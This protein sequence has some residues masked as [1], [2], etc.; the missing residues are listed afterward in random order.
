[1]KKIFNLPENFVDESLKGI[2]LAHPYELK[3]PDGDTRAIYR[4]DA[5]VKGKVAIITGGGYGH[6]PLF[7]GYV[8]EGLCDG[9]AVGNVFTSPSCETIMNVT[10]QVDSG[11]GVLYLFGNYMG[12]QM[13]FEMA[14]DFMGMEGIETDIIRAADDIASAP[15]KNWQERRGIAGIVFAYKVAGAMAER[16]GTLREVAAMTRRA[17][18]R[19]ASFGVS[20]TSCQLPESDAPI[21]EI[22]DDEMELGMG[23]HGEKGVKR[24]KMMT[25]KEI[26]DHALDWICDDICIAAGDRVGVLVN[27]LGSTSREELYI[28][29]GEVAGR[30][31]K[32]GVTVA[33]T[34]VGEYVTSME[35]AGV[36]ISVIKLDDELEPLLND[37]FSTPF[38]KS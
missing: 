6:L 7:L 37:V 36:S 1:M 34:F 10:R 14:A 25:A 21:F 26:S 27:G 17:C 35:M 12:D 2:L 13:N 20:F 4:A 28:L 11:H 16:G 5:P 15:R 19:T 31:A 18:E 29:F 8:G 38:V 24:C 33:K 23:I 3:A 30:F 22:A 32:M 9:C